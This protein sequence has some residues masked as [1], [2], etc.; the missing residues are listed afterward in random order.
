MAINGVTGRREILALLCFAPFSAF[1]Q[2]KQRRVAFLGV[3][4]ASS[5]AKPLEAFKAEL[6]QLGYAEGRNLA[7]ESR[8]G[9]SRF[10][11]MA[12]LVEELLRF[13]P[14]VLV[15]WGTPATAAAKRA[16]ATVPIVMV[17]TGDPDAT[18]L[19]A[20]L[21]RP[22][23]NITGV[24]NLGGIV[25]AKQLE[26]MTQVIPGISRIAVLRN[27]GNAS[28]VPQLKGAEEAAGRLGLQLQVLEVRSER[29]FDAA[30]AAMQA[31]RAQAVLVLADPLFF[32]RG[33]QIAE[34]ALKN[35]LPTV[36]A[37]SETAHAGL[38]MTYGAST[39]EQF[40]LGAV[41]VDRI[42]RGAKPADLPVQQATKFE[43]VINLGTAR[44]LGLQ[45][46][47]AIL[48]RADRLIE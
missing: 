27:P 17:N 10:E 5:V 41:Y 15:V 46:P 48:L 22:G 6:R 37:R 8:F 39:V 42:L 26:L 12:P 36:S 33:K 4:A 14:D 38:M 19:I 20:S 32:D 11:R 21:A 47:Q 1:A 35:R 43:F 23:G 18:G 3:G 29:D 31:P 9:E 25:T 24:A 34:L 28:L 44:A 40:R 45:L 30:F 7:I 16:T 13:K 2:E